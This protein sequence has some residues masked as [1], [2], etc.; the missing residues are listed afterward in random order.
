MGKQKVFKSDKGATL[1][2]VLV[3]IALAGIVLPALMLAITSANAINPSSSQQLYANSLLH[4]LMEVTRNVREKGWSNVATNGTYHPT[5]SGSSWSLTS[6]T[7]TVSGFTESI[8]ISSV[9]RNTSDAIVSSGGTVDPSTKYIVATVTWTTPA[10]GSVSSSTYLTRWQNNATWTQTTQS[11]F[12]GGTLT[13]TVTT[14]NTGGEVQLAN[15]TPNWAVPS[16]A[17]SYNITGNV[18]GLSVYYATISGTPY[19]FVG[20]ATGMAIVNVSNPASPTLTGTYTTTAAVNGIYVSGTTAYL[21]TAIT[22]SQFIIVNVSNPASPVI[23]GSLRVGGAKAAN[24]VTVNGTTA[25]IVSNTA[26]GTNKDFNIINVSN[27]AAPSVTG[28]LKIGANNTGVVVSGNYAYISTSTSTKQLNVVNIATPT[29][30]T[31]STTVN[32]GANGTGIVLSGSDIYISTDN[33]AATGELRIYSI[34]T[35]G[36]PTSVGDYEVGGNV[37]RLAISGNYVQLVT[38]VA[39]KQLIN[40]NVTTPSTPTLASNVTLSATANAVFTSGFYAYVGTAD[41]S[42]ELQ[43]VYAGPQYQASGTFE[44]ST[45]DAGTSVG[46]NYLTYTDTVPVGSTLKF[47]VAANNTGSGWSYVGPDGTGSTYFSSPGGIPLTAASGRYFRY[48]AYFTPTANA[49]QTPVLSDITVN[50]TP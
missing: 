31:S 4:Q 17:G 1:V 3:A 18:S 39:S 30:P 28:G 46:F 40:V 15:G 44:S 32:L 29:N 16:V 49:Q 19:A 45:F 25:Y 23:D 38:G 37:N 34:S 48:K 6:G 22:T 27:P 12:N 10:N 20:Y 43:V 36:S 8:I 33:N 42:K 11:D 41:T 35:P 47:Q 14:N 13:N 24:N 26:T 50:Y 7:T 2:E 9:Q 21:A 5:I